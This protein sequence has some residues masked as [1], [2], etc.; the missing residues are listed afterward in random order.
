MHNST[1]NVFPT[2]Q[3][4]GLNKNDLKDLYVRVLGPL[5]IKLFENV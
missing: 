2:K 5:L 1:I 4:A 3:T